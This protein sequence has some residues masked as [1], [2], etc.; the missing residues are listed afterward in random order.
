LEPE[1]E[2]AADDGAEVGAA[3]AAVDGIVCVAV[4][5]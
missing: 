4:V 1:V 3:E 2:G 5:A